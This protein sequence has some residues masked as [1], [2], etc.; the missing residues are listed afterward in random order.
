M[1]SKI[2]YVLALCGFA[3]VIVGFWYYQTQTAWVKSEAYS[4]PTNEPSSVLV[5]TYSRTGNTEAAAKIA[6]KYFDADLIRIEAAAYANDLKGLKKASD[7]AM[8]E[9]TSAS[10]THPPVDLKHYDLIVLCSPTWWFR[11]AV[12]LWEFVQRHDFNGKHVFL[13]MT[14]NS[15]YEEEKIAKFQGWVEARNGRYLDML[16][17]QRGRIY[18]QKTQNEVNSEVFN[19][20][21]S[22]KAQ[23]RAL[24]GK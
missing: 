4:K 3:A 15:R 21:D 1:L 22:R 16:F 19:A 6:A 23:W 7:D 9:V 24:L 18:W 14:G 8:G 20:L 12:P 10:I 11:P 13:I 2:L 5:V 17:V